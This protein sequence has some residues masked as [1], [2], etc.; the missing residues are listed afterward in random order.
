V[1]SE[2]LPQ[3]GGHFATVVMSESQMMSFLESS[4]GMLSW[5]NWLPPG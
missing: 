1:V 2:W 4:A 5:I 3:G